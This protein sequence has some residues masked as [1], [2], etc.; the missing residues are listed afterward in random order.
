[1]QPPFVVCAWSDAHSD[2]EDFV[3]PERA[4]EEHKLLI[5][6]TAGWLL[7][8]DEL[9]VSLY[10]ERCPEDNSYRGRTFIPKAMI[11]SLT[12]YTLSKP[13]RAGKRLAKVPTAVTPDPTATP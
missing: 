8:N 13:R 9:G 2:I 4:I 3:K 11:V 12:P 7:R 10:S 1:M 6:E 5:I